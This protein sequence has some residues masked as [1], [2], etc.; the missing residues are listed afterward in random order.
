MVGQRVD[1]GWQRARRA[2]AVAQV[3]G[4]QR[5]AH[6]QVF[7]GRRSAAQ[8]VFDQ[9]AARGRG[10]Q[11]PARFPEVG[12]QCV[13]APRGRAHPGA[14]GQAVT[15]RVDTGRIGPLGRR[16]RQAGVEFVAVGG[17]QDGDARQGM[18]GQYGKT[19]GS[20][21]VYGGSGGAGAWRG[22]EIRA[23]QRGAQRFACGL[24]F[25]RRQILALDTGAAMDDQ[26]RRSGRCSLGKQGQ[27]QQRGQRQTQFHRVRLQQ[28]E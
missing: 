1:A 28:D 20:D 13:A 2:I 11:V 8:E 12:D 16:M 24:L 23:G 25:G 19:H 10:I 18:Q 7:G 21:L 15:A 4:L 14:A 17:D 22:G 27:G 6:D 9:R 5:V 3:P 26:Q